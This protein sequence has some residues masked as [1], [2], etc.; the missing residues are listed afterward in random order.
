M[1]QICE[2][3][4]GDEREPSPHTCAKNRVGAGKDGKVALATSEKHWDMGLFRK[5]STQR[6]P[7][8]CGQSGKTA[9]R[10]LKISKD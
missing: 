7:W 9:L 5:T 4:C 10:Q 8:K 3:S 1:G 2:R 6:K